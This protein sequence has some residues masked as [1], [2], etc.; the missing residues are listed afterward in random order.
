MR[1]QAPCP[2][3]RREGLSLETVTH[4]L[5]YFGEVIESVLRCEHCGYRTASTLI[6]EQR[7]GMRHELAVAR[8]EHLSARVVR[9]TSCTVR[10]PEL[11]V[12]IEPA[13]ASDAYITNVEGILVRI[14]E[15]LTHVQHSG[16]DDQREKAA[17]LLERLARM[18]DGE[19]AFTVVLDDPLGN[20]AIV[21]DDVETRRLTAEEIEELPMGMYVFE[22]GDESEGVTK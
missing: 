7:H 9:S 22:G 12:T 8:E 14:E 19:E 15:V 3:C 16:D 21:G 6:A 4:E 10:V 1:V 13:M 20:S 2:A 18:A 11:G 5:A 17:E